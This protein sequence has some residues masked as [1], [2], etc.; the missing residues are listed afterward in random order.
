[1]IPIHR[2]GLST[3]LAALVSMGCAT[4]F[5]KGDVGDDGEDVLEESVD[6]LDVPV[7]TPVDVPTD[8][9][10]AVDAPDGGPDC[11]NGEVEDGEEC[12]DGNDVP[13]DGCENDCTWTCTSG[14]D[15]WDDD[16][17]NGEETC[18]EDHVCEDG[19]DLDDGHLVTEGPPRVIC[20]DGASHE[21]T[22][23]DG[24]VDTGAGEFCEPP[25]VGACDDSCNW[26]CSSDT[27]CPDDGNPCNGD[28]FC[29]T[30]AH[31]CD[32]SS[33][34]SDG[35]VCG[36]SPRRICLGGTCV[37]SLCGDSFLDTGTEECDDGRDGDPDDGCT[38]SCVY[39]CHSGTDCDDGEVCNGTETCG[40]ITSDGRVCEAGTD[41]SSG[42]A[43]NDGDACTETDRCDGSGTCVG[44]GDPCD[45][46][47]ACTTDTC[48]DSGGT[49][50]CTNT[51]ISGWCLIAGTCI[52][53]GT[54][55]PSDE[56]EGCDASVSPTSWSPLTG[57]SC[58]DD[59]HTCTTDECRAGACDH[60]LASTSCLIGGVCRTAGTLNPS[61]E[62]QECD[63]SSAQYAWTDVTGTTCSADAYSCTLDVCDSGVCTH[64]VD[65]SS[66]L[67]S[68]T[69][70]SDGDGHPT[71][72]CQ[73]CDA[74]VSRIAW[75]PRPDGTG[76]SSDIYG[77]T[78]DVCE[79][80][81]CVHPVASGRCLISG[82]CY[83]DGDDN[84]AN[85]CEECRS[86]T[87]PTSWTYKS[88][89][90]A[91]DDG[92]YCTTGDACDGA[93][94]CTGTLSSTLFGGT[95][96][97]SGGDHTCVRLSTGGIKCWGSGGKGQLGNGAAGSFAYPVDVVGLTSG[98]S[99]VDGGGQHTCA[100][101]TGGAAKCWGS[102]WFGRLG[103]GT[104][105]DG[106]VYSTTPVDVVGLGSGVSE[107]CAG[108]YHSCAVLTSGQVRCWGWNMYG[109][110][111]TG[112]TTPTFSNVP[113]AV[114][115][116]SGMGLLA[117]IT[118]VTC[119]S[120]HTCARTSTGEM[121]CWGNNSRGQ[122]GID[123]G[124][125]SS[126]PYP[127]VVRLQPG[128]GSPLTLVERISAGGNH[129]CARVS[130]L[131]KCW[132]WNAYGQ[133]GDNI[134]LSD[135]NA[136]VYVRNSAGTAMDFVSTI[137]AGMLHS[138]LSNTSGQGWTWGLG[139]DGQLGDGSSG[140][141]TQRNYAGIVRDSSG[142]PLSPVAVVAGGDEHSCALMGSG[143]VKCWG[144]DGA[145]QL[146]DGVGGGIE[147]FPVDVVCQRP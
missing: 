4:D 79:S 6:G 128:S 42:T 142:I 49:A 143:G 27:D 96:V 39:S 15:C 84:P 147:P 58:T 101:T 67:I 51:P 26:G 100:V 30:T 41:A 47:H 16:I 144:Q 60:I 118:D 107:I 70:Y 11:G 89:G 99:K 130:N 126:T 135:K 121:R 5:T 40:P 77:C 122:L 105:I 12:D 82:A 66:C 73:E 65:S 141:G 111:G 103:D 31:I 62:C 71:S 53:D 23:G 125:P 81:S 7:E 25:G 134:D 9:T 120:T 37:D 110:L 21:S 8:G 63:P 33:A 57:V 17:C 59:G 20:L 140:P 69:C 19:P 18:T 93:G 45:D 24:F 86:S 52:S 55:N 106:D 78:L 145:G 116:P 10:D 98:V 36:S 104:G 35:T 1:M 76:C 85:S 14:S 95:H 54:R 102:N 43:C 72:E 32:R 133:I 109:Q 83:T 34:P 127:Q 132:G 146:G 13:G 129:T 114:V 74:S 117:G 112:L 50:S 139:E 90:A 61:N 124:S 131:I 28:E 136:P 113:V 75:S 64:P 87:S 56:C 97:T 2:T 44:T 3:L 68:G 80:G 94:R 22:C 48:T 92:E 88:S 46:G 38:D 29:D 138:L 108:G 119:G 91:C 137:D 115:D 123:S